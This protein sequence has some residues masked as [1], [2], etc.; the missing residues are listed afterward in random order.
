MNIWRDLTNVKLGCTACR[1]ADVLLNVVS[2]Q[3]IKFRIT[4][5]CYLKLHFLFQIL[6]LIYPSLE[7]IP[8]TITVTGFFWLL[9]YIDIIV[10]FVSAD[11][12]QLIVD[13]TFG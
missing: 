3:S 7:F 11:V 2:T 13:K 9:T 10:Q 6:L 12:L 4:V 5:Y 1:N 8:E